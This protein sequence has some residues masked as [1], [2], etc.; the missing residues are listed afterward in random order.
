MISSKTLIKECQDT[1]KFLEKTIKNL[2]LVYSIS[3]WVAVIIGILMI[4]NVITNQ[5]LNFIVGGIGLF[6]TLVPLILRNKIEKIEGY[7]ALSIDFKNLKQD[8]METS[9]SKDNLKKIKKLRKK[10][11]KYPI[12]KSLKWIP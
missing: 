9:C 7:I 11:T 10:L 1:T 4:G 5:I 6:L 2:S 8:F 12:I 3:I